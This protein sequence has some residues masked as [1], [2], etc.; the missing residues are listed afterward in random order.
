MAGTRTIDEAIEQ[1]VELTDTQKGVLL[2]GIDHIKEEL[3][4]DARVEFLRGK[5]PSISIPKYSTIYFFKD[6]ETMAKF[7]LSNALSMY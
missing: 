4:G 1:G 3:N 6:G 2:G 5:L 7:V